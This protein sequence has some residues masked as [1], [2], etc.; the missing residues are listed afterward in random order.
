MDAFKFIAKEHERIERALAKLGDIPK[1]KNDIRNRMFT[2]IKGDLEIHMKI[3]E[4][5]LYP[6]LKQQ[7]ETR[8]QAFEGLAEHDV[9]KNILREMDSMPTDNEEWTAK[10]K[11]L[12]ESMEHHHEEEEEE[13]FPEARKILNQDEIEDLGRRLLTAREE[14]NETIVYS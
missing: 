7:A 5:I 11:V 12:T 10:L 4:S 9:G 6:L 8:G 3:E 1:E 14:L 13:L 2:S